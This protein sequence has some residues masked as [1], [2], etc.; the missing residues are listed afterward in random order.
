MAFA[1]PA[2]VL[3]LILGQ[4]GFAVIAQLLTNLT[5]IKVSPY[6]TATSILLATALGL[7]I[8]IIAALFPIRVR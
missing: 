6:L 5:D 7:V 4:V 2:W 8:P 1:V 3:G